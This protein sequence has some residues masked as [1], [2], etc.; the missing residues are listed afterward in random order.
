MDPVGLLFGAAA[1]LWSGAVYL[2]VGHFKR[3]EPGDRMETERKRM[4]QVF[5]R[6]FVRVGLVCLVL[7]GLVMLAVLIF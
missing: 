7:Y 2:I 6:F 3:V 4:A 5:G 1:F